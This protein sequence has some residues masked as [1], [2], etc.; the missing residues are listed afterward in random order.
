[1]VNRSV[2]YGMGPTSSSPLARWHERI[3]GRPSVAETFREFD[4]AAAD[5][6][7]AADRYRTG[8]RRREYRDHRLE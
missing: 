1:M 6:P 7:A 5:M 4:S 2:H 8:G 3:R